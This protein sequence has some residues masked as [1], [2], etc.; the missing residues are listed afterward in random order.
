MKKLIAVMAIFF[1]VTVYAQN[2]SAT[3]DN[4]VVT[5]HQLKL[6]NTVINYTATAGFMLMKDEN[7]SLKAKVFYVAYTKDGEDT[8]KRPVLFAYNGGPGSSSVWLHMG[9]IGPKRVVLSD[10]GEML[11]PPFS[12]VDNEYTWLD[13]T[14]I[15]FIDPMLTGFTRPAHGVDKDDFTG[16]ENDTRFVGDFIRLY[17]SKNGRWSSP[18]FIG[19]ESYGT[20]RSA[21][22]ANYLQQRYGMY[23]NGVILI[24]AILDF[25]AD[26]TDRGNDRPYPLQLPTFAATAWYH[27]K[28]SPQY[29]DLKTLLAEVENFA[30]NDYAT[31][32]LKGD[33]IS[34]TE[35]NRIAEKLHDY[36]GLSKDYILQSN[37]RLYVGRF[38]KEL[39]RDSGLT[40]G[41][42][43]SRFTGY[44]YDE[45]GENFE[46]DP[47]YDKTIYGPFTSVVNDYIKR[48]LKFNSELPY[49]ILTGR[50][51]Y[52]PLSADRY[53]NVAEALREAM[54][55][56]PFLKVWIAQGY[57]DMATPYFATENV[58]AHM[59]LKKDIRQNLH[60]TFY[61]TG[62]MVYINK[63][64]LAQLKND[65]STFMQAS[66]PKNQ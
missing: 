34:D 30:M 36:T 5:K 60:F 32:L 10:K 57:Y 46:Y 33:A 45:A 65:F 17:T 58:V 31:A 27:H 42:L 37:L 47:S 1:A 12:Y 63:P 29:A 62:H 39:M 7:D 61:E 24:S 28:L 25:G 2:K 21:G 38:N 16:Y 22:V 44:D 14:D 49:E 40:V 18:K 48:E 59:F 23:L 6:G 20:T 66:L 52:W 64:S 4:V 35:K 56:N 43:D 15:V 53:L 55:K 51:G 26:E 11:Q 54:T 41:R 13:K 3:D 9:A 50:V 19:G 8:S